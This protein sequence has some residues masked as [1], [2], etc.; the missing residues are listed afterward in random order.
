MP[1]C[2]NKEDAEFGHDVGYLCDQTT[3]L[4]SSCPFFRYK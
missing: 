1:A 2:V 3:P 4:E